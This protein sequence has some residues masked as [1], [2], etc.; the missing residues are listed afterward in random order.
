MGI[1]ESEF[2]ENPE[3][4]CPVVLLL[5]TSS[6]MRGAP[7][8][9]LNESVGIFKKQVSEDAQASL[10]V[11][12]AIVTFGGTALLAQDFVTVADFS[13]QPLSA[14]GDTPLGAAIELGLE[15]LDERKIAYKKNGIYYYRPWVWLLSDGAPTDGDRWQHA[16]KKVHAG[17]AA[18]NFS[19]FAVGV[20]GANF[21]ILKQIAPPT[22]PPLCLNG[23]SFKEMF[24]WL[25]A[26]MKKAST[27]KQG[28]QIALPPI[29]GWGRIES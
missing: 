1:G 17:E 15:K 3:P 6:S 29:E 13:P 2:V 27:T 14:V 22:R 25:S 26:S 5:D 11:E 24:L 28:D 10:R 8:Q 16:A 18:R 12:L 20:E 23:L 21:D 7:I 9:E 4:R 19:F